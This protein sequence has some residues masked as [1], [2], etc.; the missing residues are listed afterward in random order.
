MR[1][2]RTLTNVDVISVSNEKNKLTA[3]VSD[4]IKKE[5]SDSE[6]EVSDLCI[7]EI[8]NNSIADV[9]LTQDMDS[10]KKSDTKIHQDSCH[11]LYLSKKHRISDFVAYSFDYEPGENDKSY[12]FTSHPLDFQARLR[13]V[14]ALITPLLEQVHD[15]TIIH[16]YLYLQQ[17]ISPNGVRY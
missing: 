3:F 8:S 11:L 4:H 17:W 5:I 13:Q 10:I 1:S 12:E 2:G 7:K 15:R 16:F 14:P 9:V 6:D